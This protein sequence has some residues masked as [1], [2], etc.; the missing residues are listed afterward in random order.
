MAS[1]GIDFGTSN[2]ALSL[3]QPDG[4]VKLAT[5]ENENTTIPS[6][7][8]YPAR[9]RACYGRAAIESFMSGEDGR[10]MRSL[11]R[12]LGTSLMGQGT[13]VN[14]Q[15]RQFDD[16]LAAF[17][18]QM[19]MAAEQQAGTEI[20]NVVMGRPVHFS[21]HDPDADDRAENELAAIARAIG[22]K[23][24]EFQ[25]EPVAAAFAH[26]RHLTG[27]HLALI[28]DI[29]G[30]T[31]DFTIIRL[32]KTAMDKANRADDI[33]ANAGIRTGGNDFDK[34][35]CLSGFMPDFGYK[36]RYG[37]QNLV[38][39]V[40][41]FHEMSEWAKVNFQ[42]TPQNRHKIAE[43]YAQS[44][45]KRKFGRFVTLLEEELGHQLLSVVEDCKIT[46]TDK[47]E[48]VSSLDFVEN[49]F[50]LTVSRML[51]DQ[52]VEKH[53]ENIEQAMDSCLDQA[54]LQHTD[55]D[56]VVLTGGTSEVPVLNTA[57]RQ[58]FP[59]IRISEENRMSSVGLGLG[60]NSV[61]KFGGG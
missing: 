13:L 4:T 29:G 38:L 23:N 35:L 46:L 3:V 14:S 6:A 41:P 42:Y 2:S 50:D 57:I 31:S 1:C 54:G 5:V 43:L 8:F 32:S 7:V 20:E 26:E 48:A 11:K 12:I 34:D 60:Y 24:V 47:D 36:S 17:I 33:L 52:A 19:K 40:G 10:F 45:Q 58:K 16:I 51:F 18:Q 22:F 59:D 15:R 21:D 39:P 44:V 28:V 27:E 9:G 61:R 53:V 56:L 30:G 37:T 25:Y 49:G 55:I